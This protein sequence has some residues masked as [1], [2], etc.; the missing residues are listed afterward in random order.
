MN[1][2]DYYHHRDF[3]QDHIRKVRSFYLPFFHDAE[4]VLELGCGR[5]EFLELLKGAG[6]TVHGVELDAE[7]AAEARRKGIDVTVVDAR[8]FLAE[9]GGAS[10]DAVIAAHLL[11][12]LTVE[13]ADE[14]V[15][16]AAARLCRGGILCLIVPNPGSWPVLSEE[17]WND[18]THVRPYG[19]QLLAYLT[20]KHDLRMIGSG[21]NPVDVGGYPIDLGSLT[22]GGPGS[23][24]RRLPK[25]ALGHLRHLKGFFEGS[26]KEAAKKDAAT[27]ELWQAFGY[28]TEGLQAE[29]QDAH[30]RIE[31]LG[32]QLLYVNHQLSVMAGN[33]RRLVEILYAP[34][35]F[36]VVGQ[37][38]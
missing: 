34:N 1:E 23:P 30:Q 15:G 35:E 37:K 16:L 24:I 21:V 11:E 5:G 3:S 14:V 26:L 29:L 20:A 28:V 31:E 25:P 38:G 6:K 4:R 22:V 13:Q 27:R 36:F 9:A 8:S 7:M 33:L 32:E 18:P 12:H 10:F 19:T 2:A 17:F